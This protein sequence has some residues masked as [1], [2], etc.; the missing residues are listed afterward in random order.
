MF[1]STA[2]FGVSEWNDFLKLV[3]SNMLDNC[4]FVCTLKSI[5]GQLDWLVQAKNDVIWME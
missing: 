2:L 4:Y 5:K 3:G 1:V